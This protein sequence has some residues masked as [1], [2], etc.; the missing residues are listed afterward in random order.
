MADHILK[1]QPVYHAMIFAWG[2]V[3]K[4]KLFYKQQNVH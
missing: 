3:L 1:E 4:E 2:F